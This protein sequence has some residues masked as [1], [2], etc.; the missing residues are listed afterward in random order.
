MVA[1]DDVIKKVREVGELVK[2]FNDIPLNRRILEL[3]NEVIDLA[4]EKRR[5]DQE[6]EE[7]RDR[8]SFK[9]RLDFRPPFYFLEGDE[10][11][12]CPKCWEGK[13]RLASHLVF[14]DG[15]YAKRW[16]CPQCGWHHDVS[17]PKPPGSNFMRG[18]PHGWMS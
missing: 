3:E 15:T 4:R 11:A 16:N 1:V 2:Q 5:A 9:G 6:I 17:K 18:D 8:L 10:T 14:Q 13:E 12:F 7:L